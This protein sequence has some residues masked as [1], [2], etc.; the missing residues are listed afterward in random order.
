MWQHRQSDTH[1]NAPKP[2]NANT[3]DSQAQRDRARILHCAAF[4]RLQAKTQIFNIGDHDF[5]RTRL[6]H[7]LEVAQIGSG[8]CTHL[9][10]RHKDQTTYLE[11]LPSLCQI[12]AIC[13]AHDLGHPP[14]GH[15]GEVALN[16]FMHAHGGFEGNGQT[17]RILTH[18][19]EYSPKHGLDLTRR[20]LL[21]VLKYPM[22]HAQS[23]KTY[24]AK[25][26]NI[27]AHINLDAYKPPKSLLD[28]DKPAF[29]W[30]LSALPEHDQA[31][32][33]TL[34]T[35]NNQQRP[36][37]MSLDT[38]IMELADDISYG[39][40]DLEDALELKLITL[41]QWNHYVQDHADPEHPICKEHTFYNAALFGDDGRQRKRAISKLISYFIRHVELSSNG[42]FETPL[43]SLQASLPSQPNALLNLLKHCV[44]ECVIKRQEVQGLEYKGQHMLVTLFDTLQQNPKR[45][46]PRDVF[47]QYEQNNNPHR[48]ICDYVASMTDRQATRLYHT[49]F[50]PD[51]GSI[52]DRI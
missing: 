47:A 40:H 13:L 26:A 49:L 9:R 36:Q 5:Y 8:I 30:I 3:N 34:A 44:F 32:F 21:G 31:T 23:G 17:L 37:H 42:H 43:L 22:L 27:S 25:D 7:S 18:L 45:L 10:E 29:D 11:W 51:V 6:T 4:R 20:T 46:L 50:S 38:S 39:V 15:G 2:F 16:Y 12:E 35:K 19:G 33:C 41:S 52:F 24:P 48:V 14:F 1:N 28:D